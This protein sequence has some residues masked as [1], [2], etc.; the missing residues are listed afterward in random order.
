[1][2]DKTEGQL[3]IE[4]ATTGNA[5]ASGQVWDDAD[6][7]FNNYTYKYDIE[8]TRIIVKGRLLRDLDYQALKI[9]GHA[10]LGVAFNN[11]HNFTSTPTIFEAVP[12]PNFASNTETAFTYTFGAGLQRVLNNNWQVGVGY[13]FA[14]W[15]KSQLGRAAGQTMNSGLS[16]SHLYTNGILANITYLK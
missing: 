3:G 7:R 8:D 2:R 10:G 6:A 4:V 9:Y 15:G 11:A 16:L 12:T 13:E 1:M 14:D 5:K